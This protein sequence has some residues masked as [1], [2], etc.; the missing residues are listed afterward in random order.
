MVN[1]V[2]CFYKDASLL[3]IGRKNVT[4][5]RIYGNWVPL[6]HGIGH[7][8]QLGGGVLLHETFLASITIGPVF[9]AALINDFHNASIAG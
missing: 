5:R 6:L 4:L 2:Y 7:V 8:S 3:G 9:T 1:D